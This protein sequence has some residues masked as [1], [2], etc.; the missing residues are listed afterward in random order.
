MREHSLC[1]ENDSGM[2]ASVGRIQD[3]KTFRQPSDFRGR[4]AVIV[5]MWWFIQST[6]FALSPQVMYQ[7]RNTLLRLFGARIGKGVKIRPTAQV[8]YPW[9]I[10]IG[11]WSWIG[12]DVTLYSLG[13][14]S[15]G[16]DTVVS[17]RSYIC[18]GNHNYTSSSFDIVSK[19]IVIEDEVWIASDVF[20]APGLTIGLGAVI[21]ARSTVLSDLPAMMVYHGNPAKPVKPRRNESDSELDTANRSPTS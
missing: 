8:T 9:K 13:E 20:I 21:E 19:A 12:D 5:Q 14:I 3:L 17:Q 16:H 15:I 7:W 4:S 6:L 10:S 1:A 11:D 2:M 18:T